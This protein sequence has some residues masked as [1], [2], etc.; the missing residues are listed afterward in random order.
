[1]GKE[2][3]PTPPGAGMAKVANMYCMYVYQGCTKYG[4]FTIRPNTEYL[5]SVFD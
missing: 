3:T 5:A 1:M 4:N 2:G